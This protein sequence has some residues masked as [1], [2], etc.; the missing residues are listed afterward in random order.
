MEQRVPNLLQPLPLCLPPL[1]LLLSRFIAACSR[2]CFQRH[3]FQ[4]KEYDEED[5]E[6]REKK[7]G[8]KRA[9][10]CNVAILAFSLRPLPLV[11]CLCLMLCCC[12][13][14]IL[15]LVLCL[16]LCCG[17]GVYRYSLTALIT[18]PKL[19]LF[20]LIC[21]NEKVP[22]FNAD[23]LSSSIFYYLLIPNFEIFPPLPISLF[24]IQAITCD[25]H[26]KMYAP[27]THTQTNSQEDIC[28]IILGILKRGYPPSL[29]SAQLTPVLPT[30]GKFMRCQC[31][32][33]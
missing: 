12:L 29:S 15:C 13:W 22:L 3:N 4:T 5:E 30:V 19:N 31:R 27:H 9:K 28:N 20:L 17:I 7:R 32:C 25:N 10:S 21:A 2:R 14:L 18:A 33:C 23:L 6:K 1:T 11:L 16:C 24:L 8:I 26:S